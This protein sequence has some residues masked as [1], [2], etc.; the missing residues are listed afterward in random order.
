MHSTLISAIA[1]I[2][3]LSDLRCSDSPSVDE[4]ERIE[5]E[6]ATAGR[7]FGDVVTALAEMADG[8]EHTKYSNADLV[9]ELVSEAFYR[10]RT[11]AQDRAEDRAYTD[12]NAEHRL[13]AVQLGVGHA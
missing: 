2:T 9:E 11:R 5:R 13:G 7:A 4:V 6:V 3:A 12:P 1:A 10:A 8:K